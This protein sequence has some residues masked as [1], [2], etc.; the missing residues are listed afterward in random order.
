MTLLAYGE[1]IVIRQ[2]DAGSTSD[3]RKIVL[4]FVWQEL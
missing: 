1:G 2:A 3:T 4:N